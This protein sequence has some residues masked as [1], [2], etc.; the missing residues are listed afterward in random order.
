MLL[1][2]AQ[3]IPVSFDSSLIQVCCPSS[4]ASL[5]SSSSPRQVIFS[6]VGS[7]TQDVPSMT[8]SAE[9]LT[10]TVIR[11]LTPPLV[12]SSHLRLPPPT[13]PLYL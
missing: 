2:F 4:F 3:D 12:T 9:I 5:T 6:P 10:R 13:L 1:C 8:V 11:L 7:Q